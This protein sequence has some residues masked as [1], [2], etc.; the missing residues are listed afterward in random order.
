MDEQGKLHFYEV[1]GDHI[2]FSERWFQETIIANY[3]IWN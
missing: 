2:Q 1:D 3:F